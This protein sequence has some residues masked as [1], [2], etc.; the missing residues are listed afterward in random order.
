[1]TCRNIWQI[2]KFQKSNLELTSARAL[3]VLSRG[4]FTGGKDHQIGLL[5][6]MLMIHI[7]VLASFHLTVWFAV[8]L[9]FK[10][11]FLTSKHSWALARRQITNPTGVYPDRI[12]K[13][14]MLCVKMTLMHVLE[15]ELTELFRVLKTGSKSSASAAS[16]SCFLHLWQ[17]QS[18]LDTEPSVSDIQHARGLFKITQERAFI[19]PPSQLSRKLRKWCPSRALS[20]NLWSWTVAGDEESRSNTQPGCR[21]G[22]PRASL[23]VYSSLSRLSISWKTSTDLYNDSG[24][25]DW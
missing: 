19:C 4:R 17:Q 18:A 12:N 8:F 9:C 21:R 23:L 1:M 15:T 2:F 20:P 25:E 11:L 24:S 10:F 22:T 14:G 3:T 5:S 13:H 6:I 7:F 16:P